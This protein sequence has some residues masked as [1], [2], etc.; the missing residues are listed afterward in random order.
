MMNLNLEARYTKAEADYLIRKM[1]IADLLGIPCNIKTD[2]DLYKWA[3]KVL[4]DKAEDER[5]KAEAE[6]RKAEKLAKKAEEKGM[7]VEEYIAYKKMVAKAKR[8]ETNVKNA[9]REVERLKAEIAYNNRKAKETW[10]KVAEME[11]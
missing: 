11:K 1:M 4:A 10:A 9:E 8:Y 7:T 6:A 5:K 2:E 3:D